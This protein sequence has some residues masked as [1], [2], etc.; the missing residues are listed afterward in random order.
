MA[1]QTLM[2]L[3]LSSLGRQ[4]LGFHL[5]ANSGREEG[6]ESHRQKMWLEWNQPEANI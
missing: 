4:N 1:R 5:V 3:L 2:L 6:R